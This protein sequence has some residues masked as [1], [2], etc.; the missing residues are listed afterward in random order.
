MKGFGQMFSIYPAHTL[1]YKHTHSDDCCTQNRV[2]GKEREALKWLN[3]YRI[4][5]RIECCWQNE[6]QT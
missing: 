5:S 6:N 3:A 2:N 1:T 4:A